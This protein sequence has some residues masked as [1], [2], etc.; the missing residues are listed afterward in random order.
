[1]RQSAQ[2]AAALE[3]VVNKA[4]KKTN[5]V[6]DTTVLLEDMEREIADSERH[7]QRWAR[8]MLH[9][10]D[11]TAHM[12][13]EI[14]GMHWVRGMEKLAKRI[15]ANDECATK[16]SSIISG[17]GRYSGAF[18]KFTPLG[19]TLWV[20]CREAVPVFE[21]LYPG[22]HRRDR[23]PISDRPVHAAR[24]DE[25]R[26]EF[27]PYIA[28]L[29]RACQKAREVP[30]CR[31]QCSLDANQRVARL[32]LD[33]I[34][35]FVRRVCRSKRFKYVASNYV[36][37]ERENFRSCCEYVAQAFV[38]HSK[39]LVMRVDLYFLPENKRWANTLQAAKCTQRFLRALRE[40]RI[41]PSVKAWICRRE[42]GFLR[43]V[44]LHLLVAIDGHKYREAAT[45]SRL[46]GE[47]WVK[48]FSSGH[49]S[50]FNCWARRDRY[51]FNCLG[52]V[53]I[54]DQKMLLGIREAIKYMT[55]SDCVVTTG[56]SRN[57]WKGLVRRSPPGVKRGAPR[58]GRHDMSLVD[59]ILRS[60]CG[61]I[62]SD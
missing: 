15:A 41:V 29:L 44:H 8:G 46:I 23:A 4:T 12:S 45:Y 58:K 11:G 59:E 3:R 25:V 14:E 39:L 32:T 1:M 18:Y 62:R 6:V 17:S 47:A 57:L 5:E 52:T 30:E 13:D 48:R 31:G 7:Y 60:R 43:G 24:L 38:G 36:R 22:C 26:T 35:R 34:L 2:N 55:K 10:G 37:N 42:N 28:V 19:E 50:Y 51:R 49:G 9:P 54:S 21:K 56:Y 53:H 27:N 16:V 20:L 33:R 61:S 40:Q